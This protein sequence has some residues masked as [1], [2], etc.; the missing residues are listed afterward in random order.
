MPY[1][2]R[3]NSSGNYRIPKITKYVLSDQGIL[4]LTGSHDLTQ[5]VFKYHPYI[6]NK[7]D[8]GEDEVFSVNAS[9][10]GHIWAGYHN[11][12]IQVLNASYQ[13]IGYLSPSGQ[14]V[15]Q[16]VNFDEKGIMSIHFDIKGRA[17]IGTNGNGVYLIDKC[18]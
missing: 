18:R 12:V 6:I 16:Q 7:L 2:L 8:V 11:G 1:L 9:P 3:S 13:S 4:W 10:D 14:I 5:V 17:W 15:P